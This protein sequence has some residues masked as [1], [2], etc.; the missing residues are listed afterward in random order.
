MN[1]EPGFAEAKYSPDV[2]YLNSEN[3]K[4]LPTEGN[5]FLQTLSSYYDILKGADISSLKVEKPIETPIQSQNQT[6]PRAVDVMAGGVLSRKI[7][8]KKSRK[9]THKK[10]KK[11]IHKK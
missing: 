3:I 8:G 5:N 4:T 6:L 7:K 11:H 1:F 9:T 2:K 10:S